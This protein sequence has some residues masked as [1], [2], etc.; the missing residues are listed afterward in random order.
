MLPLN[1]KQGNWTGPLAQPACCT[2]KTRGQVPQT[3]ITAVPS[4]TMYENYCVL[5]YNIDNEKNMIIYGV[6]KRNFHLIREE[7]QLLCEMSGR[8]T[9]YT[10]NFNCL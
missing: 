5:S 3:I 1:G 4:K 7:T 9:P 8:Y 10:G 2:V 6:F